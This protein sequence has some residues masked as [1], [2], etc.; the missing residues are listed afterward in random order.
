MTLKKYGELV[1]NLGGKIVIKETP[2]GRVLNI[3]NEDDINI[4][5]SSTWDSKFLK[6][7]SKFFELES[8]MAMDK[9]LR[10]DFII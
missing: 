5:A 8:R 3:L 10:K 9:D 6:K 1:S 2:L 4:S 7:N